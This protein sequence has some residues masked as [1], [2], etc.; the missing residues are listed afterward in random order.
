LSSTR[1]SKNGKIYRFD[2]ITFE[3]ENFRVEKDGANLSLTPRAFDVLSFL[4]DNAGRVVEKQEIFEAVW[5]DTFVGDNALTKII[6]ELRQTLGDSADKPRYI[7]TVPKRGYRFIGE[8]EEDITETHEAVIKPV[9]ER[10]QSRFPR[11]VFAMLALGIVASISAWLLLRHAPAETRDTGVSTIAVLPFRPLNSESR[12]ESL[13]MGMA[14][15][16]ITRLS[17]LKQIVVRPFSAVRRYTDPTQDPL[18]A[19]RDARTEAVLEGSIQKAED[20]VRV[21]VRLI[22]VSD[23]TTLWSE[24]FDERFTDIFKVQ[25]SI[26]ERITVALALELSR[27]EKEQIA[28]HSTDSAEAYAFY[29]QGQ[30][31]WHRRGPQWIRQSLGAFQ[32]ALAKDPNF[33]LAHIAAADCYIMLSGHRQITMP[34]AEASAKPHIMRAL[35]IDPNLGQARSAL[36]ELKYQYEY[37]WTGAEEEFKK[38]IVLNPNVAWIHQAYGWFLMSQGRFAEAEVEMEKAREFDPNSLTINAG[39]GKLFYYSRLYD[40]AI[41]HFKGIL[42]LEPK[43]S[44]A[45]NALITIYEQNGMHAD[46]MEAYIAMNR[47]MK[48]ERVEALREAF[49]TGGRTAFL[50]KQLE[51][52]KETLK[53]N[54]TISPATFAEIYV[55][56][57][58]KEQAFYWFEKVFDE[59]DPSILQFKVEPAYD[60][61][62]DDPRYAKLLA[63]IGLTP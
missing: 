15:T 3:C 43:D 45:V 59:D 54:G 24:Q 22:K 28:K 40:E 46:A 1:S 23:G 44:S 58:D 7:E 52:A 63:R 27:Q 21:T 10:P 49:R 37:D 13:E 5:K 14:E 9:A 18:Q 32:Q 38:S 34:E 47:N 42:A 31:I 57:G 6:K 2:G 36:A 30:M 33:A 4:L 62:R 50:Q 53:R 19:G 20:R 41:K 61:L 39:R 8:I 11:V 16:L 48:P 35:E 12:D 60:V 55:R 56:L 25:D 51:F 29:I 17:N 26:A